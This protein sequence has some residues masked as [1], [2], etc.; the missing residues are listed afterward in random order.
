MKSMHFCSCCTAWMKVARSS[1]FS[2]RR[3]LIL[4]ASSST[5]SEITSLLTGS[6]AIIVTSSNKPFAAP[7]YSV[8]LIDSCGMRRPRVTQCAF[9]ASMLC[10][11]NARSDLART[12]RVKSRSAVSIEMTMPS[13]CASASNSRAPYFSARLLFRCTQH[14]GLAALP[15][16]IRRG[17]SV[18]QS[19]WKVDSPVPASSSSAIGWL[20][21]RA[22][23]CSSVCGCMSSSR[24]GISSS[25]GLLL[26]Q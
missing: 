23:V 4:A 25:P 9:S 5:M 10:V 21:I 15:A 2:A 16:W 13:S 22:S 7:S 26:L 19:L 24:P 14:C 6:S 1:V 8:T 20:A 18:T 11:I 17:R 12:W 3:P